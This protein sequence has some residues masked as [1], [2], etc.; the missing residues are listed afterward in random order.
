M[1]APASAAIV[2]LGK[3]LDGV[4]GVCPEA[5]QALSRTT[6]YQVKAGPDRF[7][8]R[9]PADGRIVGWTLALGAPSRQQTASLSR[10]LGGPAR[11][12][13]VVLAT[14]ARLERHVVAM[15]PVIALT[16]YFGQSVSFPLARSLP[17]LKGQYV[18]L[19]VPTWAP[20]LQ[21][22]LG[23]DSSWRAS[24]ARGQCANVAAQT[25]LTSAAAKRSFACLYVASRLA[26]SATFIA[27]PAP[28]RAEPAPA[29]P[30]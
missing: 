18:A 30:S 2:E 15:S 19:G 28:Q 8:Y 11:A 9:A 22:G 4:R 6:A 12:A 1:C 5:C 10:S 23:L 25:A 7:L 13:L 16:P 27:K 3:M 20:V 14:D 26:Y 17:I 29:P 24:R 21:P